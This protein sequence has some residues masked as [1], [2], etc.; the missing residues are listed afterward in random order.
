MNRFEVYAALGPVYCHDDERSLQPNCPDSLTRMR[1]IHH[2]QSVV[3]QAKAGRL[4]FHFSGSLFLKVRR[5]EDQFPLSAMFTRLDHEL[6][7]LQLVPPIRK[8]RWVVRG[9]ATSV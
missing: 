7:Q 9:R 3:A 6:A 2:P 4:L 1:V 8:I 5:Q